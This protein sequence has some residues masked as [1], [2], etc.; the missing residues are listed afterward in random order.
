MLLSRSSRLQQKAFAAKASRIGMS[1]HTTS[2]KL[3]KLAQLAK[4]TSMFDDPTQQINELTVVIK[5]DITNM[6]N[7]IAELQTLNSSGNKQ[8]NDHSNN[9]VTNLKDRLMDTTKEFK[10]VLTTRTESLKVHESRQAMFTSTEMRN[11]FN[12]AGPSSSV[13]YGA[14]SSPSNTNASQQPVL[15]SSAARVSESP[16][17]NNGYNPYSNAVATQEQSQMLIPRE[18]TYMNSRAQ[19]LQQVEST[20]SELGG[21]FQQLATMVQQQ[22]EVAIRIDN[23]V[24][25]TMAN[26]DGAQAQLL[27]YLDRISGNRWLVLKIFFVLMAFITF[28]V[29][30]VA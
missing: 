22:Q 18:D 20:I 2:Q 14:Y 28:F 12:H 9:V 7:D 13:G 17:T 25:D 29:L 6:N 30:F 11:S 16:S 26:V 19:A 1:I 23:D 4:R 5:Q 27:K 8:S 21:M 15:F 10:D 3:Q 24:D